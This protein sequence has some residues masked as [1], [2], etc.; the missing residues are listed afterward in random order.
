M[1]LRWVRRMDIIF[2]LLV[3]FSLLIFSVM[4]NIFIG[5]TIIICLVLFS[6]ISL[7]KGYGIREI[8]KM[9]Y[10]GGKQS[11][12]VLR[13]F[14]LIGAVISLW[15]ASGTIPS[16]VYYCLKYISPNTFII[17][18]FLIP[19]M[20]SFLIGTSLGTVSTVGI[21]LMILARS[22]N[23]NWNMTAGAIIAGAYF[24]D[25]CSPMSSSAV[26]V[27]NL[28]GTNMFT[29]VK[30]MLKSAIVPFLISLGFYYVLSISQPLRVMSNN[31]SD[32]LLNSF[33]IEF[34]VLIPA[35]IILILSLRR[36]KIYISMSVSIISAIILSMVVQKYSLGQVFNYAFWGFKLDGG[37]LQGIIKGGGVV[38][39]LRTC[40]V[41]FSSC[42]LAGIFRGIKMF[43]RVK[44]MLLDRKLSGHKLYGATAI[45]SAVT[46]AFGCNQSIAVVMTSEIMKDCYN[47]GNKDQFALHIENS[48]ILIAAL[49][50]WNIAALV[51]TTTM[52]VSPGG[53]IP[54]AFYLYILP[55]T[56]F[57]YSWYGYRNNKGAL[58]QKRKIVEM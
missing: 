30:N 26:L 58:K 51:P 18:S 42:C 37:A 4:K 32:E 45:V 17:A 15:M 44:S 53:Y 43:D 28:T 10:E 8:L 39:M 1:Q 35:I 20:T 48:G 3:S 5:Y 46:A 16:I 34:I 2:G 56:Y 31:L 49:I 19:C 27:A 25:R 23:V 57:I 55:I 50:P 24:G 52:G 33:K 13:V 6:L 14:V 47:E 12:V 54:Y 22:G 41:V 21:P 38:S 9:S 36:V 40:L 29:N 7:K 11:F